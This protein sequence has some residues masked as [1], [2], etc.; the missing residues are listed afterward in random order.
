MSKK[1]LITGITGQDGSYLS[2]ILLGEGYEVHGIVRRTSTQN[3]SNISHIMDRLVLHSGDMTD[4]VNVH[5]VISSIYPDE[6]YNL[7]AQSH[8]KVSFDMPVNTFDVNTLGLLRIVES[9]KNLGLDCKIYQA[10]SSAQY[11][12]VAEMPQSER[13]SF[14]P[15]N[16][17]AISKVA[18]YHV[19][20]NYRDSF[21]MK[22]Y[23]GILFNHESERR[24][25][26]FFTRKVAIGVADIVNGKK[27][28]ITLGNLEAKRD[29]GYAPEYCKWI[30]KILQFPEPTDFVISTGETHSMKE[31]V[32]EAFAVVGIEDWEKYVDFDKS[33]VRPT[34][35][36]VL[37]GDSSKAKALMDFEIKVKFKELVDIM[38]KHEINRPS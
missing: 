37:V 8:V 24:S 9:V 25:P 26:E 19:A 28:K 22:I 38:V 10:S 31:F 29:L 27:D 34:E 11:G 7:A 16:P 18:A 15:L 33:L 21:G 6:I 20:K 14:N 3:Y 13:T 32:K 1:A 23:N 36:D 35:T 30:Y 4:D 2:E 17:Y 12:K 5:N